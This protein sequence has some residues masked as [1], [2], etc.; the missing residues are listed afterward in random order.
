MNIPR[1]GALAGLSI[2]VL[3][4]TG[5][6]SKNGRSPE[7]PNGPRMPFEVL[8]GA[9]PG[10]W[11]GMCV[12]GAGNTFRRSELVFNRENKTLQARLTVW[13]GA[14]C[15]PPKTMTYQFAGPYRIE[16]NTALADEPWV[17]NT[18]L[19]D[20]KLTLHDAELVKGA[21]RPPG[22]Y[23]IKEWQ[24]DTETS[25]KD[26]LP[27][28]FFAGISRDLFPKGERVLVAGDKLSFGEMNGERIDFLAT[29]R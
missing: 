3:F 26:T 25:F 19:M 10:Q 2:M 14:D 18:D 27:A 22:L 11:L 6:C 16:K 29:A 13:A 12:P 4:V 9:L 21:N 15:Q 7:N 24:V 23:G 20:A 28:D 8:D 1:I 17:V 5:G